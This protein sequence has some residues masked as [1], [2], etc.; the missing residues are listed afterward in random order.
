MEFIR[1]IRHQWNIGDNIAEPYARTVFTQ[2]TKAGGY[3]PSPFR[4]LSFKW[5]FLRNFRV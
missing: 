3:S 5:Y 2:F 4:E 1:L